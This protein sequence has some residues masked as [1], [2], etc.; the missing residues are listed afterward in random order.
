MKCQD[1]KNPLSSEVIDRREIEKSGE[2][3]YSIIN[4]L[5]KRA[6]QINNII[7]S[8]LYK[9]L[10]EFNA[11][12]DSLDEVFENKEQI[13]MSKFYEGLPKPTTIAIQEFLNGEIYFRKLED[14]AK[15]HLMI[16]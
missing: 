16:P 6:N 10:D 2:N 14:D 4:I 9:K 1:I 3:I 8:E 12:N 5:G 7:K 13:E 11:Y 15:N